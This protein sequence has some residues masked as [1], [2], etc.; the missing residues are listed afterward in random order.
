MTTYESRQPELTAFAGHTT[1]DVVFTSPSSPKDRVSFK[2]DGT[3]LTGVLNGNPVE[4]LD[5]EMNDEGE[6][7]HVV[8]QYG[9]RR[10]RLGRRW[11]AA[12]QPSFY[13]SLGA[14]K[15]V[16]AGA[17]AQAFKEAIATRKQETAA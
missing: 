13:R 6:P 7:S 15:P 3:V 14:V 10:L 1:L 11:K 2:L 16:N 4:L 5:I 9:Q 17:I 12:G 8:L